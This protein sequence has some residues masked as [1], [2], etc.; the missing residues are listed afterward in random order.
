M[1]DKLKDPTKA[2]VMTGYMLSRARTKG[3][4]YADQAAECLIEAAE[5]AKEVG[6]LP[7]L[8]L[9]AEDVA[10]IDIASGKFRKRLAKVHKR[11]RRRMLKAGYREI[12][13][14]DFAEFGGGGGR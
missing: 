4:K 10:D 3:H 14:D 1:S 13:D 11:L 5:E 2:Q 6:E 12:T 8:L 7:A 9:V